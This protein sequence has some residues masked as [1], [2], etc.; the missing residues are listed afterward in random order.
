[1]R[2]TTSAIAADSP[3]LALL[4]A[5][6]A[7]PDIVWTAPRSANAPAR[8]N[9]PVVEHARWLPPRR[10]RS[11]GQAKNRDP[12]RQ[13]EIFDQLRYPLHHMSLM[14]RDEEVSIA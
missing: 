7:E 14:K 10:R 13:V 11:P 5:R 2:S 3:Q 8:I 6:Q 4:G 1:L 9:D 12:G